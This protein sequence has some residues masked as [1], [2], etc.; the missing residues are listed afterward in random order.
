MTQIEPWRSTPEQCLMYRRRVRAWSDDDLLHFYE[1]L[2]L[3]TLNLTKIRYCAG[4]A[5]KDEMRVRG[6]LP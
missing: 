4:E 6:I 2:G 3:D 5:I 1:L